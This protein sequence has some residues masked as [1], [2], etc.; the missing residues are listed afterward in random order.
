MKCVAPPALCQQLEAWYATPLGELLA[1]AEQAALEEILPN[2]F[3][4]HLLQVGCAGRSVLDSSLILHKV[5]M[6]NQHGAELE[7][8]LLAGEAEKM[9]IQ[10]DT[11]DAVILYHALEF[12]H[13]PHQVLREAERILVPEGHIVILG[14][15]PFSLW[16]LRRWLPYRRSAMPW[17]GRFLSLLRLRDWLALLGFEVLST[18]PLFFRPPL[19][20]RGIMSQLGRMESWGARWWSIFG[21]VDVVVA[22]KKVSTLTPIK[23]RWRPQR[24]LSSRLADTATRGYQRNG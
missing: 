14:F 11:I 8:P 20:R 2:L 9:P 16:G 21:A 19:Q 7:V 12:S 3:G 4:Y 13:D 22:R 24:S 10:T 5:V 18:R 6:V 1:Q 17:C 23:P 15:N